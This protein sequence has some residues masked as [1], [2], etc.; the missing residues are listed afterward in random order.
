MKTTV[1]TSG[2]AWKTCAVISGISVLLVF[3]CGLWGFSLLRAQYS[4]ELK[5]YGNI[6]GAILS[7]YPDA[8][9]TLLDAMQDTQYSQLGRGFTILEKYGYRENLLMTDAP[10][11]RDALLSFFSLLTAILALYLSITALCFYVFAKNHQKQE[12]RLH[13]LLESYLSDNYSRFADRNSL[14]PI[15]SESFTDTLLKLGHKLKVKTQALAEERDHTKTLVTDISHQLKT[16]VSALKN[17][18]TMCMEADSEPERMDFLGRC[19]GQMDRL[20]NL[21][22]NLVNISRLETSLITLKRESVF[23]S[24]VLTDAVNTVYEKTLPQNIAIELLDPDRECEART[25][26]F[27]DRRWT[28]EAIANLLDNAVKYSPAGSTVTLRLHRFYSYISLEVEDEGIGVPREEAGRIFQRFY[29][30]GHPSI[31]QTEGSGVGLYLARRILEEQGGTISV[32]SASKKGSVFIV[33]I[34]L[35]GFTADTKSNV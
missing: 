24:D 7:E 15:F 30:G 26:L 23:L 29:R 5:Q 1:K 32:K 8:E 22:T 10:Y 25:P 18:F 31:K 17:C 4:L 28:S 19:A 14:T 16:P 27:L 20:E 21:M 9:Q 13:E 2:F 11:Y 35:P 12:Q 3:I 34:P 33:H 6:A